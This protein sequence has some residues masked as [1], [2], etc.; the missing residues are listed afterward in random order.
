MRSIMPEQTRTTTLRHEAHRLI[1]HHARALLLTLCLCVSVVMNLPGCAKPGA[2]LSKIAAA[3]PTAGREATL[4]ALRSPSDGGR[5]WL[6]DAAML[7]H[8]RFKAGEDATVFAASV[9]ETATI[10]QN[11]IDPHAFF[12]VYNLGALAYVAA[13]YA[14]EHDNTPL[15]AELVV[16]GPHWQTEAYWLKYPHHECL[17]AVILFDQGKR[18]EAISMLADRA[19]VTA[20]PGIVAT[21]EKLRKIQA[22]NP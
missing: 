8:D 16:A 9:L 18:G 19:D 21:L 15:A 13:A 14:F 2:R 17:R 10:V 5:N 3:A 12:F 20:D 22:A 7:A 11:R 4:K 1:P 6:P